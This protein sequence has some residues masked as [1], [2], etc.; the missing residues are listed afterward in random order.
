MTLAQRFLI[1]GL[2]GIGLLAFGL[3]PT[4][5]GLDLMGHVQ[6]VAVAQIGGPLVSAICCFIASRMSTGGDRGA[7]LAFGAG[8]S[9]YFVGNVVYA[10]FAFAG[11]ETTFPAAP[12]V[13]FFALAAL[14]AIGMFHY[15]K[16]RQRI[17]RGQLYNFILIYCAVALATLFILHD[18]IA[19]SHLTPFG[20][21]VAF[22]YPAL[23]FSVAAFGTLSFVLYENGRKAAPFALLIFALLAESAADFIYARSLLEGTYALL[24]GPTQMLWVASTTFVTLAAIEQMAIAHQRAELSMVRRSGQLV[25]QAA[26]PGLAIVILLASGIGSG[27]LPSGGYFAVALVLSVIFAIVTAMREHWV[28]ALQLRLRAAVEQSR[29]KLEHS[30]ARLASVLESTTDSVIVLDR[31]W[32][33]EFFNERAVKIV[34]KD[35]LKVGQNF[36]AAFPD[37]GERTEQ[38][39]RKAAEALEPLRF[40]EFYPGA[41]LWLEIHVYPAPQGLSIFFRDVSER[42]RSHEE[43]THLAH[44]DALTGL[45]NRVLFQER[46]REALAAADS[47]AV[48]LIDLDHFKEVNDTLGHPFGDALLQEL[49]RHLKAVGR[50][51]DTIAR[52]GGD[53]FAIILAPF[54]GVQEATSIARRVIAAISAPQIIEGRQVRVGASAGIAVAEG[55][56][57]PSAI[58]RNADIALYAAKA[59]ARGAYRFFAPEMERG[60]QQRQALR[61]DLTLALS[62]NEFELAY[63]PIVDLRTDRISRFE[64]LL[65]WR[66]PA[67]GLVPPDVFIPIAEDTGL[68]VEIGAWVLRTAC[69][70]AMR[71]PETVAVAVNLSTHQFASGDLIGQ[72]GEALDESGLS[73]SRLELEITESVLLRDSRANLM[74]LNQIRDMGLRVALDDFGTGYSSLGYLQRFPYSKIKIDRTFISGLPASGE[75]QAIVRSIAGLGKSL[76]MRVTAEGVETEAQLEWVRSGC[77]EAQ[78]FLLSRPVPAA[79]IAALI[80]RLGALPSAELRRLA[81]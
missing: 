35:R 69:R 27:D 36:W 66:H 60:L 33:I 75:S 58:L 68:I 38:L 30:Q 72:I 6:W 55:T 12:E 62:R 26:L 32:T 63:Q 16:L 10:Y 47:A 80:D 29:A 49:A 45:A 21:A 61:S 31:D 20:T 3:G 64:A 4:W 8:S 22:L 53:E 50:S 19:A 17:S 13:A 1:Y 2:A 78:G 79:D 7:W 37:V 71:W 5:L 24:A 42:K 73:P 65:R 11:I 81:S 39:Y 70:E 25:V 56:T 59:E 76:G 48:M 18:E 54:P 51:G 40:E 9:L 57:D 44:H 23:W 34:G 15:G 41:D 14:F 52:L 67:N 43:I 74:T 46:L 28:I 77:D